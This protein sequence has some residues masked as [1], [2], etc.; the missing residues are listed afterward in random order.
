MGKTVNYA[1]E[2]VMTGLVKYARAEICLDYRADSCLESCRIG[3]MVLKE[4]GIAAEPR[5]VR[6]MAAN[7][8]LSRHMAAGN[9]M[10]ATPEEMDALGGW[11]VQIGDTGVPTVGKWD[12]HLV[13]IARAEKTW[14]VDLSID[15]ASRPH[16]NMILCPLAMPVPAEFLN[17]VKTAVF[18]NATGCHLEYA[19]V[20]DRSFLA[21]PG[22]FRIYNKPEI[23]ERIA[24]R[25]KRALSRKEKS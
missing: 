24:F 17:G 1:V 22:W 19:L 11:L 18:D 5:A 14:L 21:C 8:E 20:N 15:Q 16:K 10:P 4:F 23:A 25:V 9:P 6:T 7:P 2:T 13:L 12:G 3:A